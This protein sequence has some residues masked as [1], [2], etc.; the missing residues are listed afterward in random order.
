MNTLLRM[1][2]AM[3][4]AACLVS[5]S[6][7]LLL[8]LSADKVQYEGRLD[9]STV[10]PPTSI[11]IELNCSASEKSVQWSASCAAPFVQL[12]HSTGGTPARITVTFLVA[13]LAYGQNT[14]SIAFT[15]GEQRIAVPIQYTLL[16][17]LRA[18][19]TA[20]IEVT[21]RKGDTAL[22]TTKLVLESAGNPG[23]TWKISTEDSWLSIEP[24]SGVTPATVLVGA[25]PAE[26]S[27]D[28]SGR[29][30]VTAEHV[31]TAP[32]TA[33]PVLVK[34]LDPALFARKLGEKRNTAAAEI[35]T[36]D[37]RWDALRKLAEDGK[38]AFGN[39]N[40]IVA[41]FKDLRDNIA[42]GQGR[43]SPL[44]DDLA[45]FIADQPDYSNEPPVT[46]VRS[47][48]E[49]ARQKLKNTAAEADA[50]HADF[51]KKATAHNATAFLEKIREKRA[52]I[53]T[54]FESAERKLDGVWTALRPTG[55]DFLNVKQ[56]VATV[57][58]MRSKVD[59]ATTVIT[60]LLDDL[61]AHL[62]SQPTLHG[63]SAVIDA[64]AFLA[65]KRHKLKDAAAEADAMRS[66][67]RDVTVS[68]YANGEWQA[69]GIAAKAGDYIFVRASGTWTLGPFIGSCGVEG[70]DSTDDYCLYSGHETGALLV[71]MDNQI[72]CSGQDDKA[73]PS[74]GGRLMARCNDSFHNDN[75]GALSVRV[76]SFTMPK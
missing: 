6:D 61:S 24:R 43:I 36:L 76:V 32:V 25:N 73:A 31:W 14:A 23:L 75:S 9:D 49:S 68:V 41:T 33:F 44:L 74:P 47:F 3:G 57:V 15:A 56:V 17:K 67:L 10:V 50:L 2:F 45:A 38:G 60:P 48:I 58:S 12:S 13:A 37:R 40:E 53:T 4:V 72:L 29:L 46:A 16:G 42:D 19:P 30:T 1:S 62:E 34:V 22:T 8:T 64:R 21:L 5:C 11:D 66:S 65:T 59:E 26:I 69:L 63:E 51:I 35:E 27:R 70:F 28:L 7:P 18:T 71:L 54:G 55:D 39:L 52:S 20:T